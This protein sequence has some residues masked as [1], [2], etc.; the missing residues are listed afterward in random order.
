MKVLDPN[1]NCFFY[2]AAMAALD[3]GLTLVR[4]RHSKQ[5]PEDTC[6]F[7]CEDKDGNVIDPTA[8]QYESGECLDG[9]PADLMA[10]L[11]YVIEDPLFKYLDS[12]EQAQIRQLWREREAQ[13]GR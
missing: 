11:D 3:P 10:N 8:D 12:E 1:G 13:H 7:W 6:H 9:E 5:W 2:A 4:G